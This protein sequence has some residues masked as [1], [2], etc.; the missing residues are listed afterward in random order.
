MDSPPEI[1]PRSEAWKRQQDRA[2]GTLVVALVG[3]IAVILLLGM[4]L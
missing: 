4:L 2:F 1:D 3:L